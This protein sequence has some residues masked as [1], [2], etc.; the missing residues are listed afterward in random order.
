MNKLKYLF[1][2]IIIM[3]FISTIV[4]LITL[5]MFYYTEGLDK[6]LQE[7][8]ILE[9]MLYIIFFKKVIIFVIIFLG[10]SWLLQI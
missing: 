10:L 9:K 8:K 7:E 5:N 2:G 3:I 6:T 1:L 4:Y